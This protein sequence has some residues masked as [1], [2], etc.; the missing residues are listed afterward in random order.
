MR[1]LSNEEKVEL[2]KKLT[3][4]KPRRKESFWVRFFRKVSPPKPIHRVGAKVLSR[5]VHI[6]GEEQ[7]EVVTARFQCEDG[8]TREYRF[9]S[10]FQISSGKF[11]NNENG[12]LV[13][14]DDGEFIDFYRNMTMRDIEKLSGTGKSM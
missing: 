12:V 14:R 10:P 7:I 6:E 13:Y 4:P 2:Q 9:D 8:I 3:E 5:T 1:Q 11:A